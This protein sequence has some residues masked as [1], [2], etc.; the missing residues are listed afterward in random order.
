MSS[1]PFS[2][3]PGRRFPPGARTG[4]GG[5]NF[6]IFSRSATGAT[7]LLYAGPQ[8][9][10]P[11]ARIALDPKIHRTFF[12]WHVFVKGA[13]PGLYY[14]WQLDGPRNTAESGCR[15]DPRRELLDPWARAVNADLWNR[16]GAN[17]AGAAS[18]RACVS[19]HDDYDWEDDEPL[20]HPLEDSVI[21]ELH[22]GGFTRHPNAAVGSPGTFGGLTEKIPYIRSLGVTDVQLLP[23]M[24]FDTQDVP[25]GAAKRQLSNYWGY[26]PY[27]FFAAHPGYASGSDARRDFRDMVKAFHRAGIGVIL[28]VV[29]NHTAE[30]GDDGPIINF[31]GL[32]NEFF[33]HLDP[34]D[35]R[36]YRDF[37]GTGNTVNCNHP[38]VA[39]FLLQ[40]LEY[41]VTEMHVDG[42]R[43]D[44]ASVL[45]RGEDGE[46]MYHAPVLWNIEFSDVL[47]GSKLIAEAWDAGGLYQVGDFPGFRWA[48][49]NARYR[50]AL[51][52]FV[53]GDP[54]LV[55]EV[56]AR[57]AGSSD[58]YAES[59]RL[60]INSINYITC[61]DGL[62][63]NDLVSY[64]RKHNED[65][66]E[67]NRDGLD[68]NFSSNYG[69]EGPTN[70]VAILGV[71]SQQARNLVC[72]L[73]LSQ[74]VPMILAGD[75][76][77]RTQQGNNN[78]YC[79]DNAVSWFDW[80]LID[81]N[82][83]MLRFTREMVALRKRHRSLRRTRFLTG[84]TG[85]DNGM[86]DV[87]W[88]GQ[89]LEAPDWSDPESR[90]LAFTLAGAEREE[91]ELHVIIN[92]HD[93]CRSLPVPALPGRRWHLAVDTSKASPEEILPPSEQP[94]VKDRYEL[95]PRTVVVLEAHG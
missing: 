46:P 85:A 92:M 76:V 30:G 64:E 68:E 10:E 84:E 73:L 25:P 95:N 80:S 49:W 8:E 89:T 42:F 26:S 32:G 71:R 11:L 66:G 29:F 47:A 59:G 31:K 94:P 61:H 53:R 38:L 15:F 3:Q 4:D 20:N 54:G 58:L 67:R 56:A 39:R 57:L 33:Y 69:V 9:E 52:R 35:K 83:D 12:F 74:G 28:D 48:E 55:P 43:F 91:G 16:R 86:L 65:N 90:L 14:T 50:D 87:N 93:D 13:E 81:R 40:C 78:A 82:A 2:T 19:E 62:T 44:L 75:E 63:L 34:R 51:R 18:I 6:S 72:L 24:A 45:A 5:V 37:T 79:Q 60:P 21:Y 1:G 77:L 27:G 17:R 88:Y 22:V 41:W 23:I 70:D 7:L 36:R